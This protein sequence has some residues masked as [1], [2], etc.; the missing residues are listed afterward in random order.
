MKLSP[1]TKIL[2][3]RLCLIPVNPDYTFDIWNESTPEITEFLPFD[4]TETAEGTQGFIDFAKGQLEAGK[5][6]AMVILDKNSQEFIGC[7]GLHDI[8][9]QHACM[10]IWLKAGTHGQGL[11]S[12]TIKG[13]ME[14]AKQELG[15]S[16]LSYNVEKENTDS[17][18]IAE[19]L[20]FSFHREFTE[21]KNEH[22]IRNMHEYRLSF[23]A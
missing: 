19:K 8:T 3:E 15:L 14:F 13:L 11:G 12:E 17:C 5:E 2:T 6:L 16:A 10:G 4:R 20:G 22:K 18:H 21:P 1:D 7:C 9:D 23:V